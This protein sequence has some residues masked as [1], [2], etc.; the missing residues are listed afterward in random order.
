MMKKWLLILLLGMGMPV[1][2]GLEVAGIFAPLRGT[3]KA[4][5]FVLRSG[6][7]EAVGGR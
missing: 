5:G 3:K 7:D 1:F 4:H 6:V 2:A